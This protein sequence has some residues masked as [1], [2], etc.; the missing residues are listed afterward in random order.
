MTSSEIPNFVR[1]GPEPAGAPI[2]QHISAHVK[3]YENW[4]VGG[5]ECAS[6]GHS[7]ASRRPIPDKRISNWQQ[8]YVAGPGAIL[9]SLAAVRRLRNSRRSEDRPQATEHRFPVYV[10]CSFAVF[11]GG[12]RHD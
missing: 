6:G 10:Q 12:R 11:A 2:R 5:G 9:A 8:H 4:P 7:Q 3:A 1:S